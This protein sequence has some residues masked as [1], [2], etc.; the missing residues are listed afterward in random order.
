LLVLFFLTTASAP[1]FVFLL[2][3][4]SHVPCAP[5]P[6]SY[7][8]V[9]VIPAPNAQSCRPGLDVYILCRKIKIQD[10]NYNFLQSTRYLS[11]GSGKIWSVSFH[12]FYNHN[13]LGMCQTL[14]KL[15]KNANLAQIIK[16]RDVILSSRFSLNE[17]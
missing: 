5:P 13:E 7:G 15:H 8:G 12:R 11:T 1:C 14:T 16:T 17:R 2:I 3:W 4:P 6:A 9:V 10:S